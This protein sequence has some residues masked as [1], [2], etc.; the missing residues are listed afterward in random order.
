MDNILFLNEWVNQQNSK[1]FT[2]DQSYYLNKIITDTVLFQQH[3]L[4][5]EK[6]IEIQTTALIYLL[7][8]LTVQFE[9]ANCGEDLSEEYKFYI[10]LL[11]VDEKLRRKAIG[12]L[13][14]FV[15]HKYCL[16]PNLYIE[17]T[18]KNKDD[19]KNKKS[20]STVSCS[21]SFN[22]SSFSFSLNRIPKSHSYNSENLISPRF[23]K[24][25]SGAKVSRL[26]RCN[27]FYTF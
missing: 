15:I 25:E 4:K 10:Y 21:S 11:F 16:F 8:M 24:K 23:L 9:E 17:T 19:K 22:S 12:Q 5:I 13:D 20:G 1:G 7:D 3:L 18:A 26:T 2:F 27:S 14:D 6:N